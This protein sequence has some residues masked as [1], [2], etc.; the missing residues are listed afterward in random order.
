MQGTATTNYRL[1]GKL[2][3]AYCMSISFTTTKS[4]NQ[5]QTTVD[6]LSPRH[7]CKVSP[8]IHTS[9]CSSRKAILY[10]IYI[11]LTLVKTSPLRDSKS[12]YRI[13]QRLAMCYIQIQSRTRARTHTHLRFSSKGMWMHI[14]HTTRGDGPGLQM[15]QRG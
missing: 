15:L 14:M 13:I 11:C 6:V 1:L 5:L 9:L 3:S 8:F 7:R 10:L 4:G 12:N 2:Q